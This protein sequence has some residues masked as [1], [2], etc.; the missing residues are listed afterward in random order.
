LGWRD[1]PRIAVRPVSDLDSA[2]APLVLGQLKGRVLP[3]AAA[4][5]AEQVARRMDEIQGLPAVALGAA[6]G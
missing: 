6:K 5:F 1:D 4:T 3:L 2:H